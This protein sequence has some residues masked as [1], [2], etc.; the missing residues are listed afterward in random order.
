MLDGLRCSHPE[1]ANESGSSLFG[2]AQRLKPS[3]R[4][5]PPAQRSRDLYAVLEDH[6]NYY[7]SLKHL[8]TEI[9]CATVGHLGSNRSRTGCLLSLRRGSTDWTLFPEPAW[10]HVAHRHH[11]P[12]HG[13]LAKHLAFTGVRARGRNII[14]T[15]GFSIKA[16]H[17]RLISTTRYLLQVTKSLQS[18]QPGGESFKSSVRVR[19]L[20]SAVRSRILEVA[21]TNP[22]YFHS[23]LGVLIND[24]DCIVTIGTFSSTLVWIALPR[25]GIS[26]REQEIVDFLA[27]FRYVAYL[28]GTSHDLFSAPSRARAVMES[29]ILHEV[30]PGR[31]SKSLPAM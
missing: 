3:V 1:D 27:L 20:H 4:S 12:W 13:L 24:L 11:Y 7:E 2:S 14:A 16:V 10:R 25:Q 29:V 30:Q 22:E 17:G 5:P 26:L 6:S 21:S 23:A 28:T 9:H 19:L 8:W 18:I 31:L 15:G